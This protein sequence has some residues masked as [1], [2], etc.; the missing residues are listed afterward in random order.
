MED[1]NF[2]ER[3]GADWCLVERHNRVGDLGPDMLRHNHLMA[4]LIQTGGKGLS[5]LK[6]DCLIVGRANV[7]DQ[8]KYRPNPTCARESIVRTQ[9]V[10]GGRM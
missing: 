1:R 6:R 4:D 2:S 7:V 10:A 9:E 5:K 3:T 8:R